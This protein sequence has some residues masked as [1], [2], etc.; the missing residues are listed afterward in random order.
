MSVR[1][2]VTEQRATLFGMSGQAAEDRAGAG[3]LE[4]SSEQWRMLLR[5]TRMVVA[6]L[7]LTSVLR[8]IVECAVE[9]V[10]ADYGAL[11]V[12]AADG[13]GLEEFVHVGMRPEHV[14][15]IGHLPEG[16][17][18]LGVLIEAPHVVR[19]DELASHERSVGFPDGHP[20]M[21]AFLGVPVRVGDEIF[22]NLYLT[23]TSTRAFEDADEEIVVALASAAGVAVEKARL[24]TESRRRGDWLEAT[25]EITRLLLAS[26][27]ASLDLIVQ[28]VRRLADADLTTLVVPSREGS[29]RVVAADG[30]HAEELEGALYPY[31]GTLTEL[32]L[33]SGQ[34]V[35]VE[36]A[37]DTSAY[38]G[39]TLYVAERFVLGP[40]MVVPLL[41]AESTRG[42]L[43]VAR[44]RSRPPFLGADLEMATAFASHASI[45]LELAEGKAL[46]QQMALLEDR[47]RIGRDLHDHVIQQVFAA[48]L[49]V[50]AVA[51]TL[52]P[53]PQSEALER[54]VD[55]LDEA[56]KQV[57]AAIFQM[58]TARQTGLQ[59]AV[60]SVC[61]EL[62]PTLGF[63]PRMQFE[64]AVDSLTDA[65]L[66]RDGMAV[67]REA[68][69]NVAK[70]AG[71]ARATVRVGVDGR[72]LT[73][74]VG[75]D[76]R[77]I[78]KRGR[79]SGLDNL[80]RRAE[81]RGGSLELTMDPQLGGARLA[82]SVPLPA[83]SRLRDV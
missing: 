67:V 39:R 18:L 6:D 8:N 9:L 64:G 70:H 78:P 38:G 34:A 11:G 69:T 63:T 24:Y 79:R 44:D 52:G 49:S 26:G 33:N 7:D 54:V 66:A 29:L 74:S 75:D 55:S 36:D 72:H 51:S 22:G 50:Q 60:V 19:L 16:K 77:G 53:G 12:I 31:E 28:N 45:A 46:Q 83:L 48:G 81:E 23:R 71:A 3:E 30:A 17:G 21:G 62:Q 73:I 80:R 56:I 68:L 10:D 15:A 61:E 43:V 42:A 25:A 37:Q 59:S 5:A 76:G 13:S 47:A 14:H 32:V 58:R 1:P 2:G 65:E 27:D 57:R 41:G 4:L 82:W 20:P 40:V 35:R